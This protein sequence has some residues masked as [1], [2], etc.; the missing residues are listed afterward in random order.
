MLCSAQSALVKLL[1]PSSCA[2]AWLGPKAR[3]PAARRSIGEPRDQRRLRPDHHE[4]DAVRLAERDHGGVVGTVEA[5]AF[6]AGGDAGIPW[7]AIE[8]ARSAGWR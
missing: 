7:G 2:A 5:D 1:E 3:T 4:A 8:T 6:G